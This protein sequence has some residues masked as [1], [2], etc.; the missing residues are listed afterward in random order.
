MSGVASGN[1]RIEP[2][3]LPFVDTFRLE[4][5][6]AAGN[7][8][9]TGPGNGGK[10]TGLEIVFAILCEC[11]EFTKGAPL[12]HLLHPGECHCERKSTLGEKNLPSGAMQKAGQILGLA[13]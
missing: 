12:R 6:E 8:R 4:R 1:T 2:M 7:Q 5:S 13:D 9:H 10:T 11:F 3:K